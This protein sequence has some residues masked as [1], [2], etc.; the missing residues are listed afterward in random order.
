MDLKPANFLIFDDLA[1][2]ASDFDGAGEVGTAVTHK[3]VA[4]CA[5][6]LLGSVG[7][8]ATYEMDAWSLGLTISEVFTGQNLYSL[9]CSTS[10]SFATSAL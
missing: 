1:I 10:R 3:T 7:V 9:R 4:Y 5:P 2:K 8:N 6:E